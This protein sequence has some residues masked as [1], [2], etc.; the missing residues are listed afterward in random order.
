MWEQFKQ[1]FQG[2]AN[3]TA[4]QLFRYTLVGGVAFAVDIG[5]LWILT[6][7]LRIHY[8]ASAA[9]A[10]SVGLATNYGLSVAWVFNERVVG[11]RLAEFVAFGLLGIVGLGLNEI[12]MYGLTELVGLH[13]LLSK[14]CATGFTYAWNFF[15][16][17]LFLFSKISPIQADLVNLDRSGFSVEKRIGELS[18]ERIG[19]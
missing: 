17:K 7:M 3:S 15:S 4:L 10:F 13:Y 5:S 1:L 9:I 19:T 12:S 2:T 6:E 8:L 16:R 14:V 11:N 18:P